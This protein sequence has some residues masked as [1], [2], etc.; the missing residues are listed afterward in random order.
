[1]KEDKAFLDVIER[2]KQGDKLAFQ[3]IVGKYKNQVISIAYEMVDN[4]EDAKDISQIVFVKTFRRLYEN[5]NYPITNLFSWLYRVTTNASFNFIK[6]NKKHKHEELLD[7][8]LGEL[9][10]EKQDVEKI[11]Q[12]NLIKQ[13]INDSMKNLTQRQRKVF[14]LKELK[15]LHIE[16]VAQK[17][18][19]SRDYAQGYLERAKEKLR[20]T[21]TKHHP[22]L[23]KKMGVKYKK[24]GTIKRKFTD[25]EGL[26]IRKEY[27]EE[28]LSGYVLAKKYK[29]GS[30]TI[31]QTIIRAG[32]K[33][34]TRKGRRKNN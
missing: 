19:M 11:Y 20:S 16:E 9:K 26:R 21:L 33:V 7:N 23:I 4:F 22:Q 24:R 29:C 18:N 27:E 8:I 34:S 15:G 2:A 32:G 25:Q 12:N 5:N 17:T 10:D 1:M 13:A 14:M 6:R 31:R 30:A 28:G 3:Q